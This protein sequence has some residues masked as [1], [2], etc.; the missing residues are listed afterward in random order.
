MILKFTVLPLNPSIAALA[1]SRETNLSNV[2]KVVTTIDICAN[3]TWQMRSTS[4]LM[5]DVAWGWRHQGP[6]RLAIKIWRRS[7]SWQ[8][9]NLA[10]SRE[11]FSQHFYAASSTE[12]SN[13][14]ATGVSFHKN[15]KFASG[16][17]TVCCWRCCD[18]RQKER[19]QWLPQ[20]ANRSALMMGKL[21]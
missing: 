19:D 11:N 14:S 18:A 5:S 7:Y 13:V 10:K 3:P 17:S 12:A 8:E 9:L 21:V 4:C 16:A 6:E 1:S 20:S 15:M 2:R